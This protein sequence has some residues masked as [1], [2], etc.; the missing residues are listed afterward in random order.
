MGGLASRRLALLGVLLASQV[1]GLALLA[2]VLL[3]RGEAAPDAG[4]VAF[5]ALAAIAG[6]AAIA[7]FYRGLAVGA[8]GVV[9]PISATAAAVPV[10]VGLASGERPSSFQAAGILLAVVGVVLA[11][12]EAGDEAEER[13]RTAA[14]AGL[15]LVAAAG[16]GAFFV[17]MDRAS[18][19]DPLWAVGTSRAIGI[20]LIV[21]ALAAVRPRLGGGARDLPGLAAVGMFDVTGQTLFAVASGVGLVSVVGVLASLYPVA[22]VVLARVVLGERL[23][24][25]QRIGAATAVAGVALIAAG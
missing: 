20:G 19:A 3:V 17:F 7:A 1:S 22:T 10:V 4:F 21:A 6:T 11:A 23:R 5:S 24:M 9:A 15:A 12:R 25:A 18:D 8:M 2:L 13:P 14:G 16:F